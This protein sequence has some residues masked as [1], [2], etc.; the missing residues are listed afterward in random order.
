M[1]EREPRV[2]VGVIVIKN[3]L[4]PVIIYS[5]S[6]VDLPGPT[7]PRSLLLAHG[8]GSHKNKKDSTQALS[9]LFLCAHLGSNQGPTP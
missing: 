6:L 4:W 5:S 9:F 7:S 8:S 1:S 2:G 3:D